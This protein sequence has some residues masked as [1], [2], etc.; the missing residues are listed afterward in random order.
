ML[1]PP[2]LQLMSLPTVP[3]LGVKMAEFYQNGSSL[4]LV[5]GTLERCLAQP[6]A[7]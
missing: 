6:D 5:G 1:I 7:S 4:G 3:L 2:R